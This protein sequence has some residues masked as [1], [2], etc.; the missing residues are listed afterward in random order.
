MEDDTIAIREPPIR[1]SGVMGG[2]FLRRQAVKK[3]D[4]TRYSARDMYIGNV[5]NFMYHHFELLNADE[6]TY[7]LMENDERTFPYSNFGILHDILYSK[8]DE[9]GKYFATVYDGSGKIDMVELAACCDKVN[10]NFNKQ[11][12][13]TLW[14]KIDKLG[15]GKVSF[16]KVIKIISQDTHNAQY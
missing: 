7:R 10:A 2:G 15:R 14:R 12:V 3:P 13:L 16:A 8:K 5:V 9:I 4:G 11:Q 1:N 6:F